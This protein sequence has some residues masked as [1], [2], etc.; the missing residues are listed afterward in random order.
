MEANQ[1]GIPLYLK[2]F[3]LSLPLFRVK[4]SSYCLTNALAQS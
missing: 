1:S 2:S 3:S 4:L